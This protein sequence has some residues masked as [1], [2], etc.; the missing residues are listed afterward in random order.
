[1]YTYR[2]I[3][4]SITICFTIAKRKC[5][6]WFSIIT[7][8]IKHRKIKIGNVQVIVLPH[9]REWLVVT[10]CVSGPDTFKILLIPRGWNFGATVHRFC[11]FRKPVEDIGSPFGVPRCLCTDVV[12]LVFDHEDCV[13]A[14]VFFVACCSNLEVVPFLRVLHTKRFA[15]TPQEVIGSKDP[16]LVPVIEDAS[17]GVI[18]IICGTFMGKGVNE[19]ETCPGIFGGATEIGP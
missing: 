4:I 9:P 7:C 12:I 16:L 5:L 8:V 1:M 10:V 17:Q 2:A 14:L 13:I 6:C 15:T 3:T 11:T 18:K 19:L